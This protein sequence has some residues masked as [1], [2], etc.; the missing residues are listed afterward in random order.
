MDETTDIVQRNVYIYIYNVIMGI[1]QPRDV[2]KTYLIRAEYL[3]N[4]NYKTIFQLFDKSMRILWPNN[5]NHEDVLLFVSYAV[6][7]MKSFACHMF[8]SF[9]PKCV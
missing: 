2:G 8:S 9:F 1:L 3:Y 7:Y 6:S 4:V 5:V